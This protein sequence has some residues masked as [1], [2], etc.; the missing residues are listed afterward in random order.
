MDMPMISTYPEND[1]CDEDPTPNHGEI[2][3]Q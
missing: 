1:E 3:K 2:S